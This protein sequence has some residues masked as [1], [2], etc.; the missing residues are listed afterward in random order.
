MSFEFSVYWVDMLNSGW[1]L[2]ADQPADALV[3]EPPLALKVVSHRH[4]R[5]SDKPRFHI[6]SITLSLI[7]AQM[8]YDAGLASMTRCLGIQ[9]RSWRRPRRVV[10]YFFLQ[11]RASKWSALLAELLAYYISGL[12]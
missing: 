6:S 4:R 3:V 7:T 8:D 11:H 9:T 5:Q 12:S 1:F 10:N 2:D